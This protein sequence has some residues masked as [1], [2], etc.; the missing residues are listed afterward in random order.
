MTVEDKNIKIAQ[1]VGWRLRWQNKGGGE[2]FDEKP[3]SHCWP[4]WYPPNISEWYKANPDEGLEYCR[5]PNYFQDLN[6]MHE[7]EKVLDKNTHD[8]YRDNLK[9]ICLASW[10]SGSHYTPFQEFSRAQDRAEAFGKTLNL[11]I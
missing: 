8:S 3:T 6:A 7:A 4:V 2:L 9:E 11:W 5:P 10:L 1:K